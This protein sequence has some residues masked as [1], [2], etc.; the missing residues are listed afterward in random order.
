MKDGYGAKERKRPW[1]RLPRLL[2]LRLRNCSIM[3]K[4][5]TAALLIFGIMVITAISLIEYKQA[6]MHE[7]IERKIS[8]GAVNLPFNGGDG[9]SMVIIGEAQINTMAEYRLFVGYV[10][11]GT[12]TVGGGVFMAVIVLV[13]RPLKVLTRKI[14]QVDIN[15]IA[16]MHDDFVLTC[17][18]YELR[19][20]S[21]GFQ[22]ALDKIYAD[23]EKQKRFSSNVAHE[24]RTPL[25]V[26]LMKLDVY[27]KRRAASADP[28]AAKDSANAVVSTDSAAPMATAALAAPGTEDELLEIL[29]RNLI[30]LHKLVEDILLL[31]REETHP[32][33]LLDVNA[34]IDEIIVDRGEQADAKGVELKTSGATSGSELNICTD[35]VALARIIANLVDNAINYTP[36]GG[37]C[38]IS[39][40]RT[41]S[42]AGVNIEVRDNGIGISDAEKSA[43]FGMFYRVEGSRNRATGGSGIGLAIVEAAVKRLGGS[44]TIV[45]NVPQGTIFRC[46]IPDASVS[47]SG[48]NSGSNAGSNYTSASYSGSSCGR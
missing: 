23:Y 22:S 38:E 24:L 15:N 34:L 2:L 33:T 18:S 7:E 43:V 40:G 36:R 3:V 1:L 10:L 31:T 9:S 4:L 28:F 37:F 42:P 13:L 41:S 39:A 21:A 8:E 14:E 25:A 12:L 26:L 6:L 35:E 30:R 17:G 47:D 19:E 48:S 16:A 11:A 5:L 27:R 20:L 46:F 29:R 32:K 45:D 44:I